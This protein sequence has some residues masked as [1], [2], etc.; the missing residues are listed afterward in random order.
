MDRG[1]GFAEPMK[2][3]VHKQNSGS[4]I[5]VVRGK[6]GGGAGEDVE[7]RNTPRSVVGV[8]TFTLKSICVT[9]MSGLPLYIGDH[10]AAEAPPAR[11]P[12]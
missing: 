12:G 9:G 4:Y 8:K 10:A 11:G 6:G 3:P 1:L 2:K 5:I 7:D